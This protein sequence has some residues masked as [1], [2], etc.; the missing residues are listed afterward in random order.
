[1]DERLA[2]M[3]LRLAASKGACQEEEEEASLQLSPRCIGKGAVEEGGGRC[4]GHV[5]VSTGVDMKNDVKKDRLEW[6]L[7]E[8]FVVLGVY[9]RPNEVHLRPNHA[10]KTRT[11]DFDKFRVVCFYFFSYFLFF[12]E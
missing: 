8:V 3:L 7:R 6:R 11:L 9:L 4:G 12:S 10:S 5:G 2:D 1:M